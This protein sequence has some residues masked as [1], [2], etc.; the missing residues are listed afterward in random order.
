MMIYITLSLYV[1]FVTKP[2]TIYILN[3][4][5]ISDYTEEKSLPKTDAHFSKVIHNL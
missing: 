2:Q 4:E 1:T 5:N 3:N